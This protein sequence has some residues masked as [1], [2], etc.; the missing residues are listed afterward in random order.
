M[1]HAQAIAALCLL[2]LPG[3]ACAQTATSSTRQGAEGGQSGHTGIESVKG[4][5][6]SVPQGMTRIVTVKGKV[7]NVVSGNPAIATVKP[8]S[9]QRLAIFGV[10][11]GRTSITAVSPSGAPLAAFT[12]TVAPSGYKAGAISGALPKGAHATAIPGGVRLHGSVATPQEAMRAANTAKIIAG[13]GNVQNELSVGQGQQVVLKVKIAEMSR[14]VTQQLGINWQSIGNGVAIG[15]F[16][17]GFQTAGNLIGGVVKGAQPPGAYSLRFPRSTVP[18]DGILNALSSDNLAHILAEPTLTAL[19]GHQASFISGGSFPVPIPGAN[20]QIG[21][22]FK[23][24]GVQL[25]FRPVVLSDD[26]IFM[27]VKPTVSQISTQNSVTVTAGSSNLVVPSLVEQS[28]DTTVV[29]GSGQTLA[30]A[31]LLEN[32]STQ[33]DTGVPVLGNIPVLGLAFHNDDYKRS[34]SELVVLVTP[35][36]VR[37]QSNPNAFHLPGQGW[38]PPNLIQR[39]FMSRQN[40]GSP[41]MGTLPNG[42]GFILK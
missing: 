40:G 16:L 3:L 6:F 8:L 29:L 2:L 4:V 34:Q 37:A 18:I 42:V 24:Y 25:A 9:G 39:F 23:D 26:Q 33:T 41:K 36:V 13:A 27:H 20:G 7:A 17:F 5:Y 15:K 10:H 30:I 28:A 35:Y 19:S 32:Q 38:T 11:E 12:V 21:I 31:G 14:Q 1:R 22:E